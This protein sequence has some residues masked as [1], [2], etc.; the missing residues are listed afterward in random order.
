MNNFRW[1]TRLSW[2]R[3]WFAQGGD[4]NNYSDGDNHQNSD[5]PRYD[6]PLQQS[7][8]LMKYKMCATYQDENKFKS[9]E[10]G[11]FKNVVYLCWTAT[12]PCHDDIHTD[13]SYLSLSTLS[14]PQ[15][16]AA[17]VNT[18]IARSRTSKWGRE[19]DYTVLIKGEPVLLKFVLSQNSWYLIWKYFELNSN[20]LQVNQADAISDGQYQWCCDGP[21]CLVLD[22]FIAQVVLMISVI[23]GWI[24]DV[25]T[26][27][28]SERL[29]TILLSLLDACRSEHLIP[30]M[31]KH[32]IF[33]LTREVHT[34]T[35]QV[36]RSTYENK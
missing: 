14:I 11:N 5:Y 6:Q 9:V 19:P 22:V 8:K 13:P 12:T 33:A 25:I 29:W 35:D 34:M 21:Y 17:H 26:T 2:Y 16:S 32:V 20:P 1:Q 18:S 23:V 28:L 4:S 31:R 27:P 7:F 3:T 15:L 10:W 30:E 36:A 24:S